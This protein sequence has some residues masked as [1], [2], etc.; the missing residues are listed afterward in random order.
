MA[1]SAPPLAI[2]QSRTLV[3]PGLLFPTTATAYFLETCNGLP[4][5]IGPSSFPESTVRVAPGDTILFYSGGLLEAT[6]SSGEEFGAQ[7]LNGILASGSLSPGRVLEAVR[8]FASHGSVADDVTLLAI[9]GVIPPREQPTLNGR[10]NQRRRLHREDG[11]EPG[12][13]LHDTLVCLR[14]LGQW[15]RLDYRFNFPLR[16]KI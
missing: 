11:A 4:L 5:G 6:D 12:L 15:V 1:S 7:R 14:S 8:S 9:R 13:A 10:D 16:Y 2:W 3:T